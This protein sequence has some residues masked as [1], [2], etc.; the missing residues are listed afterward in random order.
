[1][2]GNK[3]ILISNPEEIVTRMREFDWNNQ[4]DNSD[5]MYVYAF[6][7]NKNSNLHIRPD[8]E[9]EFVE[10]LFRL[11]QIERVGLWSCIICNLLKKSK[12]DNHLTFS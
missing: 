5:Y 6:W 9:R 8:N 12:Q 3:V 10:D 4:S 11:K 7:Q 2:N 1:M